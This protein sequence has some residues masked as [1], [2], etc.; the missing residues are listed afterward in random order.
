[1]TR[2]PYT[3]LL[4][5][6]EL[7]LVLKESQALHGEEKEAQELSEKIDAL[8]SD[9]PERTLKHFDR[10]RKN[11]VGITK[12]VDGRCRACNMVIPQGT[13]NRMNSG[14]EE[15]VCPTCQVYLYLSLY[16]WED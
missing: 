5:I 15:P 12:E 11:G 2:G 14:K 3:T 8:K 13:L 6:Q 7:E 1:M 16:N 10:F 9:V 4:K